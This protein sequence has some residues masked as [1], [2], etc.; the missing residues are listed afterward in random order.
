MGK[1]KRARKEETTTAGS[2]HRDLWTEE[3]IKEL[4][5]FLDY[6]AQKNL[7]PAEIDEEAAQHLTIECCNGDYSS[8]QV[9]SK[10]RRLWN[11]YGPSDDIS[12]KPEKIYEEGS[13][14]LSWVQ[15]GE[16]EEIALRTKVIM[17]QKH[18]EFL[19]SPRKTRS[20]S[21][22]LNKSTTSPNRFRCASASSTITFR[23][24]W[25]PQAA[26]V[27]P[28][29]Q[30]HPNL[31]GHTVNVGSSPSLY[32]ISDGRIG[33]R[34]QFPTSATRNSDQNRR[35]GYDI[36]DAATAKLTMLRG[37]TVPER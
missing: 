32:C 5:A 9:R 17:H 4:L 22:G 8:T 14:I 26:R 25:T 37:V 2:Q 31:S 28:L 7:K 33:P 13:K 12:P 15:G 35:C 20:S 27:R 24:S 16:M 10:L 6:G 18:A 21:H 23:A 29:R 19:V 11:N 3:V 34:R 36:R 1:R 30:Q